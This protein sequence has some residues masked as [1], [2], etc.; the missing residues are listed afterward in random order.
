MTV[1]IGMI[2]TSWWADAMYM[3]AFDNHPQ[4]DVVAAVGRNAGRAQDFADRW[5]VPGV[6]TDYTKMLDEA[7]PDAIVISTTNNVHHGLAME[8]IGRGVHVLCE[9]PLAMSYAEAKAMHD[10]AKAAGVKTMVPFTYSFMPATRFMKQLIDDGYLGT[11]YH[12]NMRYY[13]NYARNGEYLWRFDVPI[14]GSGAVGDLGTHFMY[15][16][17]W[18]FGEVKAVT[19]NIATLVERD[20][21]PDGSDYPRAD[22]TAVIIMEFE[23]G[24]Q[25]VIHVTALAHEDGEFAQSHTM[26]FHGSDG[27]LW[28]YNDWKTIQRVSGA[29]ASEGWFHELPIPD[30]V[31]GNT[32]RDRVTDTY[33]ATFRD[34][35][36]M[37]RGFVTNIIEDTKP[38]PNFHDGMQV[39]RA[40]LE[41]AIISAK[42]GR[43]VTLEEVTQE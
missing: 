33:R 10:A 25:G 15:I 6:Y 30:E 26:E 38:V 43:R 8:A 5:G 14:S 41:A 16:A 21:R 31:W 34:N 18:Y 11:P 22:D 29:K 2:G 7:Q 17:R 42:E 40:I 27:A 36:Y 39:Q 37:A 24:A 13:A 23:N 20:L 19:A 12:L 35:D 28:H 9:K 4:A 3:P 1:K 32:R